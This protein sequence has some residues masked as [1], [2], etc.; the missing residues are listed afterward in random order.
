[1]RENTVEISR[2]E[3]KKILELAHKAAMLKE[4]L[5]DGATLAIYG[6]GLYFG[7]GDEVATIIKY[8]FP[9]DYERKLRELID[10]K[11]AEEAEQTEPATIVKEGVE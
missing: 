4:A 11:K 1:M 9:E 8:A 10:K 7:G 6:K 5:L 3:Y 2:N